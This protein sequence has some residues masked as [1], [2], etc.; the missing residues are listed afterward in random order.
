MENNTKQ[1]N[2]CIRH[3]AS[4][5]TRNYASSRKLRT[6]SP[7]QK[8]ETTNNKQKTFTLFTPWRYS[9]PLGPVP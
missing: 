4:S 8:F 3:F 5:P 6:N 2:Q 1:I 7:S 9:N